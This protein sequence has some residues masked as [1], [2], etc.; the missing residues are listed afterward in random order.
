MQPA[1]DELWREGGFTD[2]TEIVF[3]AREAEKTHTLFLEA[4]E[5]GIILYDVGSSPE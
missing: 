1:L 4:L 3:T 5:D 2:F